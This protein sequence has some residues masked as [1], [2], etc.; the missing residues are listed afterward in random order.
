MGALAGAGNF[1]GYGHAQ[2][3]AGLA[4]RL[5]VLLP[6]GLVKISGQKMAGI[7]C[8]QR[9]HAHCLLA[10]KMGVNHR[11]GQR[12]EHA[13]ATLRAFDTRFFANAGP[14]LV[15]AGGRIT[16]LSA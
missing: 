9:I 15:G 11:I 12:I 5:Y 14:P 10:C 13:V 2:F 8:Q 16:R 6:I 1:D 7:V 4:I 3:K